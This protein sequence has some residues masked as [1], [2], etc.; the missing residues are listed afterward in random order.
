MR[1]TGAPCRRTP[2]PASRVPGGAWPTQPFPSKPP[3][4]VRLATFEADLTN[5]TPESHTS[6]LEQFKRHQT[7]F[8]Y[9]PASLQGTIT[10]PGH[11][12]GVEW[13][14]GAFDPA[15]GVL[16]V[17]ANEAP[18]INRLKPLAELD[19]ATATPVQ[20]GAMIY[21]TTCTP[22]T[23]SIGKATSHCTLRSTTS[24]FG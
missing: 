4:L 12:G 5:V 15:T 14:G 23:A 11:Q 6:A 24:A 20:R 8:L 3:P 22:A 21:N 18:T 17:N 2:V 9:T 10:T 7:G 19:M 13:G 16:Y 1:A